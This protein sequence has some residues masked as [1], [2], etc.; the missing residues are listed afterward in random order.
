MTATVLGQR[1]HDVTAMFSP[2][3]ISP[4]VYGCLPIASQNMRE[5]APL[6]EPLRA[7][8]ILM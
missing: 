1:N 3:A 2:L 6:L 4:G 5:T 7:F 8:C